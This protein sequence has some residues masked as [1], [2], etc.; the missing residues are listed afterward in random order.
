LYLR[1]F[2]PIVFAVLVTG[3]ASSLP[4]AEAGNGGFFT[5][6]FD[7]NSVVC[8]DSFSDN[9][10]NSWEIFNVVGVGEGSNTSHL[11]GQELFICEL[12]E[13][14][15]DGVPTNLSDFDS[16]FVPVQSG[17][18]TFFAFFQDEVLFPE[19]SIKVTW[20]IIDGLFSESTL[21]ETIRIA[22][23]TT[24]YRFFQETD[25][26]LAGNF[27]LGTG[28][29]DTS[30]QIGP[31]FA[32][33][34]DSTPEFGPPMRGTVSVDPPADGVMAGIFNDV[35][36]AITGDGKLDGTTGPI[37]G[38][39]DFV[40]GFSWD[41]D[42]TTTE[43]F[44]IEKTKRLE[45]FAVPSNGG[46][47]H[48]PPT[49]GKNLAGD[50]QMVPAKGIG[51]D[52]QFWTVTENFHEDFELVQML[53]SEHTISNTIYCSKGVDTCNHITLSA[54]P[55]GTDINSA[56]WKVSL[57]KDF[58]GVLT[59]TVDDPDSYLGVTTCTSQVQAGKYWFTSCTIDF[60]KPM[61]GMMLGVQ[62]WDIYGGVRNF[63]FND[64]IE[65]IDTFGYPYV[66]TEFESS[67][68]VPRLC[69]SDDPDKRTSCAFTEKMQLEIERAEKLLAE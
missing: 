6:I 56:L 3:V 39:A 40:F 29:D 46:G 11:D 24:T 25:F 65:I 21:K 22:E 23:G 42:L 8:L 54:E 57:D 12:V 5:C 47:E 49:I 20:E 60:K 7:G 44:T 48:E 16:I 52:G 27:G 30:V 50:Q 33:Q 10:T 61:P 55:Y 62:V 68:D 63:Y 13:G 45:S 26:D 59:V 18:D 69:L 2:L 41:F 19:L 9:I 32:Q 53:T 37:T 15:C 64:G 4:E 66:D 28:S 58:L 17:G 43:F 34:E 38:E 14:E 51:I 31:T 1:F 67:L 35:I 36:A